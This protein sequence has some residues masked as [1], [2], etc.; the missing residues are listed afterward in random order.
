MKAGDTDS[1]P[2]RAFQPAKVPP[3]AQHQLAPVVFQVKLEEPPLAI[4]VGLAV[5]VAVGAGAGGGGAMHEKLV[6][7]L[8]E[9]P[10]ALQA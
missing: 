5:R 2:L 8:A 10:E 7:G 4:V 3:L 1:V 6:E 9:H